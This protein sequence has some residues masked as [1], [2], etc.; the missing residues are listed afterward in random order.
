MTAKIRTCASCER[1]FHINNRHPYYGGCPECGFAGHY[2]ARFVHG[3]KRYKYK[4]TQEVWLEKKLE[5]CRYKLL[6]GGDMKNNAYISE[7][8]L[9]KLKI[10][11]AQR[12]DAGSLEFERTQIITDEMSFGMVA[13]AL[14][15]VYAE[16]VGVHTLKAPANW[17]EA[18]KE[19]WFPGGLKRDYPVKYTEKQ[20]D[21]NWVYKNLPPGLGREYG[22]RVYVALHDGPIAE[23]PPVKPPKPGRWS[24]MMWWCK[25]NK[26]DPALTGN[27]E[28]A[29]NAYKEM[30]G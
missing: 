26:L 17:W 5:E 18:I 7:V 15:H 20:V 2:G 28:K 27:W 12:V 23:V 14:A 8:L 22:P 21:I 16:N 3:N 4:K 24:W 6:K 10:V 30:E 19:R 29:E 13:R 11:T 25:D 1:I 9:D